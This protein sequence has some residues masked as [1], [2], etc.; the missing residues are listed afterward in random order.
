VP[1]NDVAADLPLE[2]QHSFRRCCLEGTTTPAA[3]ADD[4][5]VVVED[6]IADSKASS[7]SLLWRYATNNEGNGTSSGLHHG[8]IG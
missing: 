5:P 7:W 2:R 1:V 8:Y 3:V 4:R 6:A